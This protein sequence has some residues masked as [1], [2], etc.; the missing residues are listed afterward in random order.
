MKYIQVFFSFYS[1]Y[2]LICETISHDPVMVSYR[3]NDN[4]FLKETSGKEFWE[5]YPDLKLIDYGF[6]SG[7]WMI[8]QEV[9][10]QIGSY[11][12]NNLVLL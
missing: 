11:S 10:M 9:V 8:T 1:N 7:Q 2:I 6:F 12:R 4:K 3:G 5:K